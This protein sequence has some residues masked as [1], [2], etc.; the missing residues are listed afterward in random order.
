MSIQKTFYNIA[1][2]SF[3]ASLAN[4]LIWFGLTFWIF[5]QTQSVLATSLLAGTFA[6]ANTLSAFVFGKIVD[7]NFKKK[8]MVI[9]STISLLCFVV[10]YSLFYFY[11][12]DSIS[13]INS[14]ILWIMIA[15]SLIGVVVGNMRNIALTTIVSI[16]FPQQEDRAKANGVVGTINGI[17]FMLTSII[18]GLVIGFFGI[19][20]MF[21]ISIFATIIA[22]LH[23][24]SIQFAQDRKEDSAH[25]TQTPEGSLSTIQYISQ[26]KGF[27]ALI[28]FTT[29]NNF[30]GGVFMALMDAYGLSLISVSTWGLL[31]GVVSL[32][33]ICGGLIVA[34]FGLGKNPLQT[35]LLVNVVIWISVIL[36]PLKA[37]VVLLVLGMWVWMMLAPVVEASEQTVIQKIVPI[38]R[39]GRVVGLAQSIEFSATPITAFVI[40]PLAQFFFI[41]LMTDGKGAQLIGHWFGTGLNRG[42]GIIFILSGMIGLIT[43]LLALTSRSYR[44][45]SKK[46]LQETSTL[47]Q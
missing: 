34:R 27:W 44:N 32:A 23:I 14:Y 37:S 43:T 22:L 7:H 8:V 12:L 13:G 4:G 17:S 16:L 26:R 38:E 1:G 6:I 35:M 10:A 42:L 40:G 47:P 20:A 18:S 30:L 31:L 2:N 25:E 5:L 41:P 36:F 29:F 9:S 24:T 46:Y 15:I 21:L 11:S 3:L 33:F 28:F 19:H 39:Q 45:L